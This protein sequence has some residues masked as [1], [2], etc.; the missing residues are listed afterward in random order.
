MLKIFVGVFVAIFAVI[1]FY[2]VI[3]CFAGR[4][5]ASDGV[6]LSVF[7]REREDIECLE[8]TIRDHISCA[9]ITKSQRIF[10]LIAEEIADDPKISELAL[11]YGAERYITRKID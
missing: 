7:V 10:L 11:K 2:D 9:L 5:F 8:D 4:M 3:R 6:V 1:G